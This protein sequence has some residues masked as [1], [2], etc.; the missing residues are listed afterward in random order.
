MLPSEIQAWWAA[1]KPALTA[2]LPHVVGQIEPEV[3]RLERLSRRS[4]E[5]VL[6]FLGASGIGKSTLINAI[7]AD[8]ETILPAGGTGPLTAIATQV[9][10]SEQKYF[11]VRYQPAGKLRGMV[12]NLERALGKADAQTASADAEVQPWLIEAPPVADAHDD[13]VSVV[14]ADNAYGE[15]ME[16]LIRAAQMLVKGTMNDASEVGPVELAELAAGLRFALGQRYEGSLLEEDRARL[17]MVAEALVVA[18]TDSWRTVTEGADKQAFVDQ[19]TLH[20]A[21]A[22]APLVAEIEV[23]WPAPVLRDGVVLVDLPGLGIAGDDYQRVTEEFIGRRARGV[24][25]TVRRGVTREEVGLIRSSGLWRRK[26]LA[27]ENPD[28]D[29]CDLLVAVTQIDSLVEALIKP[30]DTDADIS[31]HYQDVSRTLGDTILGQTRQELSRLSVVETDDNLIRIAGDLAAKNVLAGLTVHPVSAVDYRRIKRPNRRTPALATCEEDTGIPA[32]VARVAELGARNSA[33]LRALRE[34][35]AGRIAEMANSAI[36]QELANLAEGRREKEVLEQLRAELA[37]FLE[38]LR[39]EYATR[40]GQ[41][42]EFLDGTS[43]ELIDKLVE[44]AQT[45]ARKRVIR[46]LAE[47]GGAPWATLRAA[48]VRGGAFHGK[49]KIDLADDIAQLFQEPVSAIWGSESGLLRQTR[50]RT[51]EFGDV[52]FEMTEQVLGWVR[53][54]PETIVS[55]DTLDATRRSNRALSEQLGQVGQDAADELRRAVRDR[56]LQVTKPVINNACGRFVERGDAVGRG[57]KLRMVGLFA[58]LAEDSMARAAEVA[59]QLLRERFAEVRK[60]ISNVFDAWGDP[61]DRTGNA[62]APAEFAGDPKARADVAARLEA[63][64]LGSQ[65]KEVA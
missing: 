1:A 44:R 20:A 9:R 40:Q 54:W 22:L 50:A 55:K 51:A 31:K 41:F 33:A 27:A 43:A 42:R 56:L 8:A 63:V 65:R 64:R 4:D 13:P 21:G 23:G 15:R 37:R 61:L 34:A 14:S 53:S 28:A 10:Y 46:Y 38:P 49:R 47:L 5:T 3:A 11:K 26:L 35:S 60:D 29:P 19:L 16:T 12:L 62:V 48:V 57:V 25:L 52:I 18:R 30:D 24:V 36:D 58:D 2:L 32:L 7:V 6:C 17:H 59:Q 45:D 39:L